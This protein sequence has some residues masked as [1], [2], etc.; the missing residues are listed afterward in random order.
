MVGAWW[1]TGENKE[2]E[3]EWTTENRGCGSWEGKWEAR[4]KGSGAWSLVY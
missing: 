3:T 2:K 4:Q 1:A